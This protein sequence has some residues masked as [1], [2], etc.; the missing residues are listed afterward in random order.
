[1]NIR[2][3]LNRINEKIRQ[4][5]EE[6]EPDSLAEMIIVLRVD[7]IP[8]RQIQK[9]YSYHSDG[10]PFAIVGRIYV[11]SDATQAEIDRLKAEYDLMEP[12]K[13]QVNE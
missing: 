6:L 9:Q 12:E 4:I 3:R 11:F 7:E 13:E 2:Q 1:M 10:K 8:E 5:Q